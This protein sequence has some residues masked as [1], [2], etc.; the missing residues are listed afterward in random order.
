MLPLIPPHLPLLLLH[1]VP[2]ITHLSRLFNPRHCPL[3]LRSPPL[4]T[5]ASSTPSSGRYMRQS[6][7]APSPNCVTSGSLRARPARVFRLQVP[8]A[9]ECKHVRA[10]PPSPPPL[11]PLPP[12][13]PPPPLPPP[14]PNPL[15]MLPP[16][17][18]PS[19]PP[20]PPPHCLREGASLSVAS[21]SPQSTPPP[22]SCSRKRRTKSSLA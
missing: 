22:C 12:P 17:P 19:P 9:G 21:P 14:P 8:C 15:P 20:L 11:P 16:P 6:P 5:H 13:P 18:P 7:A 1:R 10:G 2:P 4:P 3:S